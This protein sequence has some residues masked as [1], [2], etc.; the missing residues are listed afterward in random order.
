MTAILWALF[1]LLQPAAAGNTA[2]EAEIN[3][4]IARKAY[5][6]GDFEKALFHFMVS[7]RLSENRNVMFNIGLTY[8]QLRRYPEA[9]R[10]Y[11]DA[12]DDALPNDE[13]NKRIEATLTNLRKNVAIVR[14]DSDPPGATVY[15]QRKNLGAV[16][17]TPLEI[18]VRP[19][20]YTF[21]F[22]RDGYEDFTS[23]PRMLQAGMQPDEVRATLTPIVG[24]VDIAGTPGASVRVGADDAEP[25][26]EIPCV[27]GL[28]QGRQF[29]FF[30]KA[31]YQPLPRVVDVL[32]GQT[33]PVVAELVAITGALVVDTDMRAAR[34]EIDGALAGF[35]PLVLPDVTI[36]PHSVRLTAR[37][38]EPYTTQVLIEEGETADLGR[39]SMD[40]IYTVTAASRFAQDVADA[41]ASI[42]VIPEQEL[43]A[44]GYQTVVE[45]L[46]GLRGLY[47]TNDL[48]YEYLGVRGFGRLGDYGNRVLVT[49]DGHRM[50]DN[51]FGSSQV[52]TDFMGDLEDVTRIEVVRGPGSA[53][54][55]SNAVFGVVNVV[56][57][58]ADDEITNHAMI[59]ASENQLRGRVSGG[60]SKDDRG[61]FISA[62]GL[63]GHRRQFFFDEYA[64]DPYSR[65]FS[66]QDDTYSR[67]VQA[68]AWAGNFEVQGHFFE[69]ERQVPTGF[70]G[71]RLG[72][73]RTKALDRKGFLEARYVGRINNTRLNIRGF[74]D[75]TA[76]RTNF[77]YAP[78]PPPYVFQ[79]DPY[80]NSVGALAQIT[81]DFGDVFDLT[82]GAETRQYFL[83]ELRSFEYFRGDVDEEP[84]RQ[85][86]DIA[87]PTQIYSG[88]LIGD[89]HP[90]KT[91]RLNLGAR[92]DQYGITGNDQILGVDNQQDFTTF[93]P[94]GALILSPGKEVVKVM[95]GT[96]FRAPSP[97]EYYF[98]DEGISSLPAVDL[99]PERIQTAEI[100]WTHRFDQ[101][102]T[103]SVNTYFNRIQS[104]VE[105]EDVPLDELKQ[106][107]GDKAD[108]D[109]GVFRYTSAM[110]P[111]VTLG[112]EAEVRRWWR[113][114]WMVAGQVSYQR[115]RLNRLFESDSAAPD[116]QPVELTNSPVW[117][118]SIMAAVPL[119]GQVQMAHK[120]RGETN[121]ITNRGRTTQGAVVWDV[122]LT[123]RITKPTLRYG[124]GVRNLLDFPVFHP[125][126]DDLIIDQ[127]PQ[128][129]RTFF[130]SL[131]V[132]I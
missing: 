59:S 25:A 60:M 39:V 76:N 32:E 6:D 13:T 80:E 48:A 45:A 53:L 27:L 93:N 49:L 42:N 47:S 119:G 99:E 129:G 2:D 74:F 11:Q 23:E 132:D 38:Y 101:V 127:L 126:G 3:F 71:T 9:Y 112:A 34:V 117:L 57:K 1:V 58:G 73:P 31:G 110:Q 19:G 83:A 102:L 105:T 28:P 114:G 115:T 113:S 12:Y 98:N 130:A 14:V 29:L 62:T 4:Q 10:W 22:E 78:G 56:T 72:D 18:P 44:F 79:D 82:I 65:G 67:G 50:N 63:Y 33:V 131:R 20:R 16:G 81:Q 54:Y 91:F 36:G 108:P 86:V 87:I 69:R 70:F 61:F 90:G 103:S 118:A 116:E 88:Y 43:H 66:D 8:E 41:P 37:G 5:G 55:G 30:D 52:G 64:D 24:Q 96:A 51:L 35:T 120:I 111:V 128:R 85:A 68:K 15:L 26:C 104:L 100:E 106:F 7:N 109:A 123:G 97:F 89:L 21:L 40:P 122:T 124:L 121:R 95:G 46:Q 125:G 17:V 107:L 75:H 94:R 77:P 92:V 84:D